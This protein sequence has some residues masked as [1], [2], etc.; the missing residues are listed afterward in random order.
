MIIRIRINC[1]ITMPLSLSVSLQRDKQQFTGLQLR[2]YE[3]DEKY[4][5]IVGNS[6]I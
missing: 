2:H 1:K 5:E 4:Q 3:N 6:N